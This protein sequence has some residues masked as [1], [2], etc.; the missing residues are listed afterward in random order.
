MF[1]A[2]LH[3]L[4]TLRWLFVE[5]IYSTKGGETNSILLKLIHLLLTITNYILEMVYIHLMEFISWCSNVY[6]TSKVSDPS[7]SSYAYPLV[8][9]VDVGL[10]SVFVNTPLQK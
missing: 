6:R 10:E 1:S 4:V 2:N 8:D 7:E 5:V 3:F 9:E